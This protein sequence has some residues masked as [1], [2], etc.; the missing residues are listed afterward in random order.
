MYSL[1]PISQELRV[2]PRKVKSPASHR[3]RESS[4]RDKQK[5]RTGNGSHHNAQELAKVAP[6]ELSCKPR[7]TGMDW[8]IDVN[9]RKSGLQLQK[10]VS[11][12]GPISTSRLMSDSRHYITLP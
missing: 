11:T 8:F 7:D 3:A 1:T 2:E 4:Q 12:H 9:H 6:N 5:H 10:L